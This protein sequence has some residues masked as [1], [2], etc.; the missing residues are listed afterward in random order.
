MKRLALGKE[1]GDIREILG[2][3]DEPLDIT[4][5]LIVESKED[6][7]AFDIGL[8]EYLI[9]VL[10]KEH[11]IY[12]EKLEFIIDMPNPEKLLNLRAV[13]DVKKF[14]YSYSL[15]VVKKDVKEKAIEAKK[16][17]LAKAKEG[18]DDWDW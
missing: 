18:N 9:L 4:C 17:R 6:F 3:L 5:F 14:L 12:S 11:P 10:D 13:K 1:F 8:D 16:I 7:E 2:E 15:E